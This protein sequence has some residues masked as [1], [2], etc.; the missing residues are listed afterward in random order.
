MAKISLDPIRRCG[1]RPF[2]RLLQ[3]LTLVLLLPLALPGLAGSQP[4]LSPG[5]FRWSPALAPAGPMLVVVSLSEQRAHVYRNGVRI[6][7]STISSGRAGYETPTGVFTILQKRRE[8]Y[9]N[10]YDDAPMPWMQRLTW[11][12]IALHAGR[13]PGYPASHGCI[14]LPDAFAEVLF[15]ATSHG[16]TV[17][18]T[19]AASD[20]PALA[21]PGLFQPWDP[22]RRAPRRAAPPAGEGRWMPERAPEG[23]M[24]LVLSGADQTL[25]VLRNG[26]EIGRAEVGIVGE[27]PLGERAYLLLGRDG[28]GGDRMLP[29]RPALRWQ[30]IALDASAQPGGLAGRL[31][32]PEAFAR[33][34]HDA[35]APGATVIVTDEPLGIGVSDLTVLEAGDGRE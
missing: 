28:E 11:D 6:G 27:A 15:G 1:L 24:T 18:I 3:V 9:S 4:V 17:V 5:E 12:G 32:L 19:D 20:P 8:H 26:V 2:P 10:L 21:S 30:A 22:E 7:V 13:V 25:L 35:L 23:P 33:A 16:M 31:R 34:V 14:R 29:D